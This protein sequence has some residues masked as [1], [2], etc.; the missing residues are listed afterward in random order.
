LGSNALQ[1]CSPPTVL[2]LVQQDNLCCEEER[3]WIALL[4]WGRQQGEQKSNALKILAP[5][6]RFNAM[7]SEFFV[8]SVV[9]SGVLEPSEVVELLSARTTGRPSKTFPGA[10]KPRTEISNKGNWKPALDDDDEDSDILDAAAPANWPPR[11]RAPR[12]S[13]GLPL[14]SD[15]YSHGALTPPML[16]IPVGH[17]GS[18]SSGYPPSFGGGSD[19]ARHSVGGY[20]HGATTPT[21][22]AGNGEARSVSQRRA[23][24]LRDAR[25]AARERESGPPVPASRDVRR[26][27]GNLSRS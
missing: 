16:Q 22:S 23:T 14:A 1:N 9:S 17:G 21:S 4:A 2:L 19:S 26:S 3:L 5:Y 7:S 12:S 13:A 15:G 11:I 25:L 6:V 10:H 18:S 24:K 20:S 8:D 27:K